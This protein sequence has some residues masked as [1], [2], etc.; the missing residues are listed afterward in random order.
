M[1]V[2]SENKKNYHD[3]YRSSSLFLRLKKILSPRV[4]RLDLMIGFIIYSGGHARSRLGSKKWPCRRRL[5]SF[6][7]NNPRGWDWGTIF[8]YR[9]PK[10]ICMGNEFWLFFCFHPC[11]GTKR[12]MPMTSYEVKSSTRVE[13]WPRRSLSNS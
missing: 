10:K 3:Q 7:V 9:L 5:G 11:S 12:V 13:I 4:L 6:L 2:L 8:V 1:N